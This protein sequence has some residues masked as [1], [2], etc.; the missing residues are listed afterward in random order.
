MLVSFLLAEVIENT[1]TDT[2][3]YDSDEVNN[4][5]TILVRTYDEDKVQ[6][7]ICK[8]ANARNNE[9]PLVGE[10]VLIFQGTNEFS[11][12]DKFRRQWYYFPA[13]NVQSDINNNALPGI[14]E[15]QT[16]NVNATGTQNDLGKSFKEKSISKLQYFEGDSILEGRFGNSIRLGSTVNNGTYSLQPTW[17]GT[18][19]GD[20]IIIISNAHTDKR[21]KEFTIESLNDDASSFYLTSMQQLVDLKLF[22]NPTKSSPVSKFKTSQLIGDAN[23]IILRAKTDSII[24]DSPNRITLGTP[25]V[26]IGAENAGHPLVKGDRLKMILNDLVAV[27]NAG[28]IGP[29]GIASA[30]L[31]QGKLISILTDIGKLNSDRHYFDK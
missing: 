28:V 18:A 9:I 20:P 12:A 15:I 5:S 27:I 19:D 1:V 16:S 23:R 13:Y 25:E 17:Q 10:H 29:A 14:A 11:T 21:N 24:L 26:R 7:L 8:P 2:Y 6:E 4:V 3:K 30:P 22:R 31:Q